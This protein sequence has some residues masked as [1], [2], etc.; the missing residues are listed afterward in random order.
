I[1]QYAYNTFGQKTSYI[2]PKGRTYTYTY[3]SNGI[4]LLSTKDSNNETL[5]NMTY[6]GQHDALTKTD[7]AGQTTHYS[8]NNAGQ[9]LSVTTP[10]GEVTHYNYDG[11]GHL[12]S[13]IPP[14][15]GA[16]VT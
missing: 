2:D 9:V 11:F 15:P 4:D 3:A 16:G 13:L 7:A 6:D 8:Y 1:S 10:M 5:S 14:Q 12:V